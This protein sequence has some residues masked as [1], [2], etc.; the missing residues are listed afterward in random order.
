MQSNHVI[1]MIFIC[2]KNFYH[3]YDVKNRSVLPVYAFLTKLEALTRS[4]VLFN[5]K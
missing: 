1:F 5:I 4:H 3:K 2:D